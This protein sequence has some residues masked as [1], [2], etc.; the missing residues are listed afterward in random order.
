MT[1]YIEKAES[2]TLPTIALRGIVAFPDVPISIE[3]IREKSISA[4]KCAQEGDGMIFLCTQKDISAN[5]PTAKEL[6]KVG[7][8]AKIK[9]SL[10]TKN[11][12]LRIVVNGISRAKLVTL[13]TEAEHLRSDVLTKSIS[14]S[15]SGSIKIEALMME[16]R[17]CFERFTSLIPAVSD[18]MKNAV[19]TIESPSLLCDFIASNV[20][21]KYEHKQKVLEQFDPVAR[22]EL[23][24]LLLESE[25]KLLSCELDIHKKVKERL[26]QNQRNFYLREQMKVIQSELGVDEE[27]SESEE[28]YAKIARAKLPKAVEEKLIKEATKLDKM[29][30][31]SAEGALIRN[32]LD[33]CTELPWNRSSSDRTDVA[34]AKK[35]LEAD[36]D[37][38]EKIKERILEFIAVKQ[39]NPDIKNQII[40]LVGPPGVGKTSIAS[41]VARALKREFVRVSLGGVRDEADIRGHR[42]TYIGAMPGRIIDAISKS[43]VN[44]PLIL[45]DEIDKLT[46]DSHGDPSSALLEVL[47]SEQNKNFR[48]HF[49]ELP[50]DLSGCMFIATANTLDTVPAPLIDRMEIIRLSSYTRDEKVSIA[51]HHLIPKQLK[52]HG[53]TKKML[54]ISDSAII[55]LIEGY[56]AEAGVRNL[57]REI[58]SLMRKCA[59]K[60]IEGEPKI[61]ITDKN[62]SDYIGAVKYTRE[63]ISDEDEIG[64]VNGLAY[65]E[66]G[67][68]ML[69]IEVSVLEG[70]GK[71]E[72]TGSLGDVMKESAKTAVSVARSICADYGIPS[73]F[74]KT[75]DIHIHAPEGAIPKDGPSAG[76]TMT[77]ALISALSK[78][79]VK[80]DVAMT[81]EI[82]LR[83]KVLRIGGLKEKSMAA[84]RSG[85]KTILIPHG[86]TKD[87]CDIPEIVKEN[88][89][90]IPV[91]HASEAIAYALRESVQGE[92]SVL[93]E[94]GIPA[95]FTEN[96][97]FY[98][99]GIRTGEY[100]K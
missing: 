74:Y 55:A 70:T 71:L 15:S 12:G 9:Q 98:R 46:R 2:L 86:N 40:C 38:L 39:L 26:D 18:E 36:H 25:A 13:F 54:G 94:N 95:V 59:K 7:C 89:Q 31:G 93:E 67:G 37:G 64:V 29:Q 100:K 83:G 19:A 57:E 23:A 42:K 72:L 50:F 35:I 58:G 47:D 60:I 43:K 52:R 32:Y 69:K 88:I 85:V 8:V 30:F 99:S 63:M 96:K 62:L 11:G 97:P 1:K 56:T 49:I 4:A 80:R 24:A 45:L 48:D 44:N 41:S 34:A 22:L 90:F 20:L 81:G 76:V 3:L 6:Y 66:L 92:G 53:L 77:V 17:D 51:K 61:K 10:K 33:I 75:K 28:Y 27:S 14:V 87:I 65:T 21:L 73:D 68:D 79:A 16:V 91:K 84:Y 5:D 78:K 82:T